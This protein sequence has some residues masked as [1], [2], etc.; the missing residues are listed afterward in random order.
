ME[1]LNVVESGTETPL[2]LNVTVDKAVDADVAG[3]LGAG[4]ATEPPV[5]AVKVSL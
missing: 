4:E 5:G 2:A 3:A 1:L